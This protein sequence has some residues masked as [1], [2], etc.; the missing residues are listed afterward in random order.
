M[1]RLAALVALAAALALPAGA[2]AGDIYSAKGPEPFEISFQVISRDGKPKKIKDFRF[3][4]V[5]MTCAS[6]PTEQFKT[7]SLPPHFGPFRISAD[8]RFGRKFP[9][10]TDT[11]V[12]ETV[13]R[14]EFVNRRRVDGTLKIAGDYP[15]AGYADCT[16]SKLEWSAE[17]T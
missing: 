7:R 1:K 5:V 13:I 8:G 2:A 14:G 12:G 15:A 6:G 16:S 9:S 11:F 17:L 3:K 10:D 4:R